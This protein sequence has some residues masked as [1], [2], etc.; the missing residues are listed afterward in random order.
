MEDGTVRFLDL[1]TG[2][3][4]LLFELRDAGWQAEMVGVDYSQNSV[5]LAKQI[6]DRRQSEVVDSEEEEEQAKAVEFE[7]F[8]LLEGEPGHWL[9]EG[10][11]IVLDKGT[12][13]AISLSD[14]VNT[15]GRRGCEIYGSRVSGL[16]KRGGYLVITSCNWTEDELRKWFESPELAYHETIRFPSFTFGGVKGQ[17]VSSI[18]FRKS[19]DL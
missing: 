4:H 8:D 6:Q 9:G 15:Q 14:E 16:V 11:D 19:A 3:G 7:H 1:G 12:F 18:C 17:T 2:N 5:Q 10:F 13:D